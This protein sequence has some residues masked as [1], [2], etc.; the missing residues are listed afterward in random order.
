MDDS[1]PHANSDEVTARRAAR[2]TKGA[3]DWQVGNA[4]LPDK[5]ACPSHPCRSMTSAFSFGE[6]QESSRTDLKLTDPKLADLNLEDPEGLPRCRVELRKNC[7][8][9]KR[10]CSLAAVPTETLQKR[11]TSSQGVTWTR[12]QGGPPSIAPQHTAAPDAW[13][14]VAPPV[15]EDKVATGQIRYVSSAEVATG[16]AEGTLPSWNC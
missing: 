12:L 16:T 13:S 9:L 5:A 4:L 3:D 8:E 15:P 10:N 11:R 6:L 7:S 1:E 14:S 2:A